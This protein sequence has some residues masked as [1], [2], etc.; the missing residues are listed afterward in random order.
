[1][2]ALLASRVPWRFL[3]PLSRR[4]VPARARGRCCRLFSRLVWGHAPHCR[5]SIHCRSGIHC[6]RHRDS[7]ICRWLVFQHICC[8]VLQ[9]LRSAALIVSERAVSQPSLR[10]E[11]ADRISFGGVG[12]SQ[13]PS[14]CSHDRSAC[15]CCRLRRLLCSSMLVSRKM[16]KP[17]PLTQVE[18]CP[19]PLFLGCSQRS[20][21]APQTKLHICLLG[22][23]VYTALSTRYPLFVEKA[24]HPT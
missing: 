7:P 5:S 11:L 2:R 13:R 24:R 6:I 8:R 21:S 19:F 4:L 18:G 9:H 12:R 1:V 10:V 14:L 20:T 16:H 3:L 22:G 15:C 17:V 23:S